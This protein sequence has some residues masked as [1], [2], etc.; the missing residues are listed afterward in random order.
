MGGDKISYE[1]PLSTPTADLT[2]DKLHWNSVL[3]TPDG[4]YLIVDVKNFYL[5]K[6]I[7]KA[8]YL[9]IALKIPP[10]RDYQHI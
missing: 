7:N 8:E 5:Y 6:P 3:S 1:G 10:P 2:T 4:K 9:K